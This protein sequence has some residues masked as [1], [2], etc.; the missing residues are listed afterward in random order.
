MLRGHTNIKVMGRAYV[1][2]GVARAQGGESPRHKPCPPPPVSPNEMILFYDTYYTG[3]WT[4]TIL[5]PGLPHAPP[6]LLPLH[7][8]KACYAPATTRERKQGHGCVGGKNG[9]FS[10][11]NF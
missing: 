9:L 11:V 3:L 2:T 7:F 10:G 5:S 8:E 6:P 1:P 4:A